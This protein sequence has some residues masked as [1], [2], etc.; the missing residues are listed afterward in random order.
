VKTVAIVNPASGRQQAIRQWP[1]LLKEARS[2]TS[3]VVTWWTQG[4]GH[5]EVLAAE[6]R[7]NGFERVVAAGG[8][9][10]L[11]EV[12]NGLWWEREGQF[13]SVGMV[14]FGMGCDYI[15]NFGV[16]S[17]KF[18]QLDT[19]LGESLAYVDVGVCELYGMNGKPLQRVFLNVLG[20]GYDANVVR[21]VQRQRYR[22]QGRVTYFFSALQE[23]F[24]L[25]SHRLEGEVD[26]DPFQTDMFL[27]A[28]GLGRYFGGGMMITPWASPQ[29]GRFHLVWGR[30]PGRLEVLR[31][32]QRIYAGRH[33]Q[34]PHV[35]TCY[36][37]QLKLSSYPQAYVQAEGELI[38]RTPINAEVISGKLCF[39]TRQTQT[40]TGSNRQR[41]GEGGCA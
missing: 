6:A 9:G 21:R 39:A 10:T 23:L 29:G 30:N 4:P 22:I 32:L 40:M 5:A 25:R 20:V 36:G 17:D 7:R 18:E 26:G 24:S 14:S 1:W 16:P 13:P 12:V 35:G 37:R 27:F 2:K 8:D 3:H 11:F 28:A 38:G 31:L 34:H 15:R 19:A 33:L 41:Q